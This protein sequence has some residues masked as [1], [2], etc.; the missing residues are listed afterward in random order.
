MP[1]YRSIGINIPH[2]S[3]GCD[4]FE[5]L[6]LFIIVYTFIG[7]LVAGF[8]IPKREW[9]D[10][11]DVTAFATTMVLLWWL[12]LCVSAALWLSTFFYEEDDG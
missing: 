7:A 6:I 11:D 9:E 1:R 8:I 4:I 10:V 3:R 12:Q 2:Y 5:Q